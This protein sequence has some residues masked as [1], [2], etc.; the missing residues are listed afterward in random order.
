MSP[1]F[2]PVTTERLIIRGMT[3]SDATALW[4]RRN[5]PE[6]AEYQNWT[7]PHP[8][9]TAERI[10][11]SVGEMDGVERDGWWMAT[12]EERSTGAVVGDLALHLDEAGHAAEVGYTLD[13]EHWGRG[14]A[15]EGLTALVAYC[16]ETLGV[17]RVFGM[18]HPDN[19]ASAML[20]ERTGFLF[21]GHTRLSFSLDGDISDDWIYGMTRP[22]WERW[23]DRIRTPPKDVGLV[24]VTRSNL[25]EVYGVATHKTQEAFVAPMAVSF[26]EALVPG[27]HDGRPL[28]P[29]YRAVEADGDIVGFVM[30]APPTADFDQAFIRR[31]LIDRLHQRRGIGTLVV[32]LIAD[33]VRSLGEA[34]LFTSHGPGRGGPLPFFEQLGF[35][36]TGNVTDGEPELV[37]AL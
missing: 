2:Q 35:T 8:R 12:L 1:V 15:T 36:P 20:M 31:L 33:H 4:K 21:E 7:I 24:K 19:P 18:L 5:D 27:V 25:W 6:V 28:T 30:L 32:R 13:R 17:V 23:R 22:D 34:S 16:F 26:A 29:W 37:L 9:E 10:A 14:F 11:I 3:A